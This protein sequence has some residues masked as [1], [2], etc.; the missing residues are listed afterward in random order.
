MEEQMEEGMR[1]DSEARE[2][3]AGLKERLADAEEARERAQAEARRLRGELEGEAA[4]REETVKR[5]EAMLKGELGDQEAYFKEE[6]RRKEGELAALKQQVRQSP[7]ALSGMG[8]ALW[9]ACDSL[10]AEASFVQPGSTAPG[11]AWPLFW[12]LSACGRAA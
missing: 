5:R 7:L 2:K 10:L 4:A 12:S 1:R 3:E 8:T 6:R 9:P 11:T